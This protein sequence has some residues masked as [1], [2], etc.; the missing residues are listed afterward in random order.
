MNCLLP[1]IIGIAGGRNYDCYV[2]GYSKIFSAKALL[3]ILNYFE[4]AK[5]PFY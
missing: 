1:I 4:Q 5:A 3:L 2:I